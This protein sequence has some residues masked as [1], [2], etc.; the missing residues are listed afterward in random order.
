MT[1]CFSSCLHGYQNFGM[2]MFL[3]P[4][5]FIFLAALAKTWASKALC[6]QISGGVG[7]VSNQTHPKA[8]SYVL[9]LWLQALFVF[10]G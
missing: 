4:L 8:Y 5:L 6:S 9:A 7:L 2:T 3:S 10:L 1:N